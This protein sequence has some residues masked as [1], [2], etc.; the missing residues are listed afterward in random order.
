MT[1]FAFQ[2]LNGGKAVDLAG[3]QEKEATGQGFHGYATESLAESHPNSINPITR[4]LADG[5]IADYNAAKGEQAQP[6]GKNA[7][8]LNPATAASAVASS[9]ESDLGLT[10]LDSF[11]T[12]LGK[13][14][15]W[16]RVLKV[17]GGGVLLLS[18]LFRITGADK[19]A[20]GALGI[21]GKAAI[22]A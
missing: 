2:G 17:I 19:A 7:S 18:G 4:V 6:G 3:V 20:K 5:W 22:L 1:W 12:A 15:T 21:A 11:F 10:G 9:A 16:V 14:S 8:I 13:L